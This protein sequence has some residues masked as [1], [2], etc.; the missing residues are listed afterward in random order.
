MNFLTITLIMFVSAVVIPPVAAQDLNIW[1]G[2]ANNNAGQ[3]PGIY[4]STFDLDTG[5][6]SRA[7]LALPLKGAGWITWHPTLP[8]MYSTASVDGQPS[9]CAIH[10]ADDK[11]LTIVQTRTIS[12][13]S[14]FLTTDRQGR[15]LISTQYGGGTVISIPIDE[16]GTLGETIQEIQHI[17]GSKVVPKVQ[18]QPHPHSACVSPSNR[19]VFVPDL[20]LDQLVR[21][22][23]DHAKQLL[24]A[25][26]EP[27]PTAPGGGPRH[28]RFNESSTSNESEIG[29]FAMVLNEL[30]MSVACFEHD[31]EGGLKQRSTAATLTEAEQASEVFNSASEVRIHRSGK[32]VYTGNRGHDSISVFLFSPD[33][34]SLTRVQV[35]PIHGAWP[36]NFDLTPDG[37]WLIVAG[38]FTNSASVFLINQ[39]S[40]MLTYHGKT[41]FVPGAICVSIRE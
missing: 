3:T 37:K 32:F 41:T 21:Y 13:G 34:G 6:I 22:E 27:V 10:V 11:S 31:G 33:D 4:R 18:E 15:V 16:D 7:E 38:K 39:D 25:S 35:A 9:L 20:G 26:G 17:G 19:F 28:M 29:R 1:F 40:G 24:V 12:S 23:I 8:I 14:C 2:T 5:A 36:R 30:S